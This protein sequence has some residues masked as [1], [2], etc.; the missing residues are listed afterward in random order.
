MKK[1]LLTVLSVLLTTVL[2]NAQDI[3]SYRGAFA[4]APVPMWTDTWTNW[5]PQNAGYGAPTVNVSGIITTNT[6]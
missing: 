3:T 4:P 5:D 2:V 6:T 1:Q